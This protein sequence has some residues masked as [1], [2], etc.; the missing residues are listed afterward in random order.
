M[1]KWLLAVIV[2]YTA[3]VA[4][5]QPAAS[6][7]ESAPEAVSPP[8]SKPT[9]VFDKAPPEVDSALR[10]RVGT[11]FQA[12]IDGK[13]RRAEE[14]IAEDSK[15]F[16][17]TMEKTRY[18]A[19]DIVRINYSENFTKATVVT[20]V[21]MEW[22]SPRIGVMIV[23][24]PLTSL[25]RQ[26]NGQWVWYVVPQKDWD[27][28]WGRMKPGPDDPNKL[29]KLFTGV[30]VATVSS[31]VGIDKTELRL[32]SFESS[33]GEAVIANSM[34]GEIKLRLEAPPRSGLQVKLDKD[35]LKTGERARVL[36]QYD[37]LTKEPKPAG[38]VIVHVEPTGQVMRLALIFEIP[39]DLKKLL[40]KE[41]QK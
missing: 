24:P 27:T 6:I 37:P 30:D 12:H 26:D 33:R 18:R 4:Q 10:Q 1:R 35:V 17:Y 13:F 14:V 8:P 36:V 29:K 39:P 31:Q 22:R 7:T 16:F 19:F 25:W 41:A 23:K 40:P 3:A 2:S 32:S 38:E 28:P 5:I 11:F 20:G 15:D 21:E 34:P 9:D